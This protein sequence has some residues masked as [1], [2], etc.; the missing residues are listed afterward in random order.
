MHYQQRISSDEAAELLGVDRRTIY[1]W[2]DEGRLAYPL[3][4]EDTQARMPQK[5]QRG[6]KRDPQSIRYTRGRHAFTKKSK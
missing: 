3:T 2:I 1:R 4:K 5:R 6:P